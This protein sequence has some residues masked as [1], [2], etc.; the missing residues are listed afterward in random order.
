MKWNHFIAIKVG[1]DN[2]NQFFLILLGRRNQVIVWE[3]IH[4][5]THVW[6]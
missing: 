2:D 5:A 3:C 4:E 1:V 6:V